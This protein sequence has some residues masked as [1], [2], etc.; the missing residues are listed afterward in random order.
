MTF[1][2]KIILIVAVIA[3]IASMSL[4]TACGGS[5]TEAKAESASGQTEASQKAEVAGEKYDTEK[6]SILV[7]S[8]WEKM[9]ITGGVQ[10]Y[11]GNDVMQV[12]VVGSNVTEE[13]DK[14]LTEGTKEQYGGTELEEVTMFGVKFY[15]TSFTYSGV[16][17]TIYSGVKNGEQ[18]KIQM[19][20]KDHANNEAIIA[21]LESI[22]LK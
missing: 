5:K 22:T 15:K 11:K 14:A 13:E 20:G 4:I 19:A 17:Q 6:F 12:A 18:V 21:M 7:P 1:A 3:I 2:K 8:G 16:D 10:I 9:D